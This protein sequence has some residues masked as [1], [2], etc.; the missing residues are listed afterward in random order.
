MMG[1]TEIKKVY[2]SAKEEQLDCW[3]IGAEICKKEQQPFDLV[4][5]IT[6]GGAPI[7]FYL[8]EFF[9]KYWGTD[10]GFAT[11]R[12][13]SYDDLASAG[14]VEIGPLEEV[15][16]E[17]GEGTRIIV[18]DDIFDRG[19]TVQ[20]T[21][22]A[23]KEKFSQINDITI[24]TLYYKPD[25]SEVDIEPDYHLKKFKSHEWVVFPH[26]VN[27]LETKEELLEF[28]VPAEIADFLLH[29]K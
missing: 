9:M 19:K 11:L 1:N 12:T 2:I 4:I 17:L 29:K 21:V 7:A 13:R 25:N 26:S 8:H 5:G 15:E 14:D 28:G 27:D 3:K 22:R 24:A 23:L 20:E 10:V 16:D 18:V 6:R